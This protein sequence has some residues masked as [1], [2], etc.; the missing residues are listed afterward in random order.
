MSQILRKL[1][2]KALALTANDP[3]IHLKRITIL[4]R[5]I[6]FALTCLIFVFFFLGL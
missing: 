6:S 2:G 4:N 1:T 3:K 5:I